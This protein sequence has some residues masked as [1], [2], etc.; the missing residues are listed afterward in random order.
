MKQFAG[1]L[2]V[3]IVLSLLVKL[4]AGAPAPTTG[5]QSVTLSQKVILALDSELA[6]IEQ[7]LLTMQ[8]DLN[9]IQDKCWMR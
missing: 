2:A 7:Q 4:N 9:D 5:G 6:S 8:N 1:G 3:G